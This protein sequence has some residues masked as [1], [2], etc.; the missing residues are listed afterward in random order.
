MNLRAMA[1]IGAGDMPPD[2]AREYYA[3]APGVEPGMSLEQARNVLLDVA[4]EHVAEHWPQLVAS[5]S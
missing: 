3:A 5:E 1:L 2:A 4:D